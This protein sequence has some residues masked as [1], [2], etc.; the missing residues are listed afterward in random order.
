[1]RVAVRPALPGERV[2]DSPQPNR[3]LNIA[4]GALARRRARDARIA[5]PK[6]PAQFTLMA[7]SAVPRTK[8][9]TCRHVARIRVART[10]L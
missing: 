3:R 5:G 1:L 6:M 2:L 10:T 9:T 7:D 4:N 8:G